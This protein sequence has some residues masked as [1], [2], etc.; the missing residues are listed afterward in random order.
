MANNPSTTHLVIELS[1]RVYLYEE[2]YEKNSS[3]LALFRAVV[4]LAA[5]LRPEAGVMNSI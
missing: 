2:I 5:D 4:R 1:G 3:S